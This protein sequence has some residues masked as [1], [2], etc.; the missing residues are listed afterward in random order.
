MSAKASGA[1]ASV[2]TQ[3]SPRLTVAVVGASGF[4]GGEL[5]R[6][7]AEHPRVSLGRVC[8]YRSAGKSLGSVRGGL[9]PLGLEISEVDPP[10]LA[11]EAEVAFLALPHGDSALLAAEL[12]AAGMRVIDLGSDFRLEDAADYPRYYG[13]SHPRPEFLSEAYYSLPELTGAIA[14][15]CRLVANP[16]CFATA[17]AMGIVPLVKHLGPQA[18]IAAMGITGSSGSGAAASVKVHHSLRP[19][20]L[21]AYKPLTHQHLG[22]LRQLMMRLGGH[23]PAVD[24]VPHSGPFIRG[25]HLTLQLRRSELGADPFALLSAAYADADLVDVQRGPVDLGAVVG[26]C[27]VA[28]GVAGDDEVA[29]VFV[30][31]DN[32]LKGGS[33]QAVQN[34][35]LLMGWP[36]CEGLPRL[37]QWP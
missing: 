24:F 17:L 29:V 5:V 23:A 6:L 34:L 2:R 27:R 12:L 22:E 14:P 19:T 9:A 1:A 32:L 21:S 36:A 25:I 15:D 35:N 20:N 28:I 16:G 37:G 3:S 7:L 13:R 33:G 11:K 18:R 26:S 30:A 31:I 10:Q 8:G 4:L